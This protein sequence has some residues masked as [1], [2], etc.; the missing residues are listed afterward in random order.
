MKKIIQKIVA[1]RNPDFVLDPSL[2]SKMILFFLFNNLIKILRGLKMLCY[3]KMP[4]RLILSRGCTFNYIHNITWGR[5]LKLGRNVHM[6]GL[7]TKGISIGE[8]VSIGA[9]SQV[10]V[11][12]TLQNIGSEISIEDHVGIGEFAY[13]GGAGPVRIGKETIIGQYLSIHPENHQYDS[14]EIPIRK[15][16]VRRKGVTIG[17][18]CWIGSKVTFLDGV[19]VGSHCVVAA[20]AVVTKTFPPYSIIGGVPARLLKTRGESI[21]FKSL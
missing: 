14:L 1:T 15:Q 13:I 8:N 18:D 4:N 3:F 7:G 16:G 5:N 12:T 21:S 17:S 6:S 2:D 9:Y 11:S 10:V 20:G 19:A